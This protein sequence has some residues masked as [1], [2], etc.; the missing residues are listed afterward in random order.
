M[1]KHFQLLLLLSF[2][3]FLLKIPGGMNSGY[4]KK[5]SFAFNK[6]DL[7][8]NKRYRKAKDKNQFLV[9][10]SDSLLV[11]ILLIM[12]LWSLFAIFIL[13]FFCGS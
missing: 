3:N 2:Y 9:N 7:F 1:R 6:K 10:V 13:L 12:I 8:E 5:N 4:L 11:E